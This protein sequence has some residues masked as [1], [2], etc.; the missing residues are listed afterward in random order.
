MVDV[1]VIIV[2][3]FDKTSLLLF[4]KIMFA[5]ETLSAE[6]KTIGRLANGMLGRLRRLLSF[7]RAKM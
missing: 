6:S 7:L 2:R 4:F 3:R 5:L 1:G